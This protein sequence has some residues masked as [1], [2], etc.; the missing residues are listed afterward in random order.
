MKAFRFTLEAVQTLRHRQEQQAM[1]TYV[2]SLLARQ[3]V[4]DRLEAARELILLNQQ[5]IN[6]LLAAGCAASRIGPGPPL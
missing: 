2:H 3:Q 1:E 5:E 6:R 4:L